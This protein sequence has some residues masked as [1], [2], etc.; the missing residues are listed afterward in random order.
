MQEIEKKKKLNGPVI[1]FPCTPLQNGMFGTT[2]ADRSAYLIQICW[3]VVDDSKLPSLLEGWKM[4]VKEHRLLGSRIV[5]T[6][7]G[8]YQIMEQGRD[9]IEAEKSI[10]H[11]SLRNFLE[12]DY[13]RGFGEDSASL[14]RVAVVKDGDQLYF[15]ITMHHCVYDGWT[16]GFLLEDWV[17]ATAGRAIRQTGSFVDFVRYHQS[18]DLKTVQGYWKEY[19]EGVESSTV[20][21]RPK[22]DSAAERDQIFV[23]EVEIGSTKEDI[24]KAA[25]TGKTTV[26]NLFRLGWAL[27][28]QTFMAKEDVVFGEVVSGRDVP[29]DNIE[30]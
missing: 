21:S 15:V 23:E 11:K 9:V 18:Q 30:R 17:A 1:L 20:F 25:S 6:S 10:L 14:S 19:L 29:I 16:L 2:S 13:A 12:E 27:T 22:E 5:S 4:V 7:E 3:E 24:Q 8:F 28:L 26:A